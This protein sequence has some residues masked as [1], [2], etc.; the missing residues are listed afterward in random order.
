MEKRKS[1]LLRELLNNM[2]ERELNVARTT[3]DVAITA[4][5]Y[6]QALGKIYIMDQNWTF[7]VPVF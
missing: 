5:L 6:E 4:V 7:G 1:H 2:R 3:L